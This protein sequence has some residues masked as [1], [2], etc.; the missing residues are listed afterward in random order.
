MSDPEDAAG[1][2]TEIELQR[3]FVQLVAKLIDYAYQNPHYT[4]R[5]GEAYRTPEQAAWNAAHGAG[6][7]HTLHTER[8][9]IDLLLDIDYVWQ[10]STE[11]YRPLGEYW[12]SLHP[13]ARWGGDFV[14]RPD[15][16][17][18]SLAYGGRA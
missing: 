12:K 8:L 17:H 18:F 15:G 13:L 2:P 5:F 11:A 10:T 6:I 7:A 16:N 4:L 3:L 14:S 9:A 1:P